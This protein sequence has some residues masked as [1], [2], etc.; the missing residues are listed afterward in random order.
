MTSNAGTAGLTDTI[1]N[2]PVRIYC[3]GVYDLFHYGHAK[4]L[5]QAKK[6]F[7]NVYL[8]VGVCSDATTRVEKGMTVM[9]EME[10]AESVRHCKWVDE[11]I[12]DVPWIITDAFLKEHEIDFVAHD[13]IPYPSAEHEDVYKLVKDQGK[14]L[15]TQRTEGISTS[16]IITDIIHNYDIYVQRNLARG[17]STKELNISYLKRGELQIK[18]ISNKLRTRLVAGEEN[19]RDNWKSTRDEVGEILTMLTERSR[20]FVKNFHFKNLYFWKSKSTK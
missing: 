13:D 9:N 20:E 3:D 11:V 14:F 6:A 1:E 4:S 2:R 8:M 10:R 17:V 12:Q 5:E 7:P 15:A 19:V 16:K 18:N